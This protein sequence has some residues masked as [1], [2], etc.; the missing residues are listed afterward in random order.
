MRALDLDATSFQNL[1]AEEKKKIG[2]MDIN[3][4]MP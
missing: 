4:S 3:T 2:R 1:I